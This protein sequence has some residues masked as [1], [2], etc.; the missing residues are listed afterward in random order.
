MERRINPVPEI[1]ADEPDVHRG[2]FLD[3]FLADRQLVGRTPVYSNTGDISLE[4]NRD[5]HRGKAP[6]GETPLSIASR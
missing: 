4:K 5:N 1:I 2:D 3:G 6:D